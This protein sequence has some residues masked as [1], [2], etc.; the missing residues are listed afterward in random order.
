MNVLLSRRVI[1]IINE[2][3]TIAIDELKVGDNDTLSAQVASLLKADLL[4][5][6]T[7]VPGLYSDNPRKNPDARPIPVIN[8][9]PPQIFAMAGGMAT[10]IKAADMATKSGV[11]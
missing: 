10:K 4:V 2:N 1:P 6:L 3:D 9:I 11:R 5:L 8:E 7:D